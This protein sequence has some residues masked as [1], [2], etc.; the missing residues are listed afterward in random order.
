MDRISVH[1]VEDVARILQISK[2]S[3][4]QLA[5]SGALKG[6]K[7]PGGWRFTDNNIREYLESEKEVAAA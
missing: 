3:V 1:K 4:Y 6:K 7:T 2:T 5:Q